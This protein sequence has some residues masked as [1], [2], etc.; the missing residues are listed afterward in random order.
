MQNVISVTMFTSGRC[1]QHILLILCIRPV[2]IIAAD[3]SIGCCKISVRLEVVSNSDPPFLD[4]CWRLISVQGQICTFNLELGREE[5]SY[6]Q[7]V[8]QNVL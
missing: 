8:S 6:D 1:E 7:V 4:I 5:A 3:T 2:M